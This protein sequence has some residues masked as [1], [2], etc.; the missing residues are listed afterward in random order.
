MLP[1]ASRFKLNGGTVKFDLL[2]RDDEDDMDDLPSSLDFE[3]KAA[4]NN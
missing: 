4:I 2:P 3:P 1:G